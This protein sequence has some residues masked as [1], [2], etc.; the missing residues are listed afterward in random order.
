V[1]LCVC[2]C[3]YEI[4][5]LNLGTLTPVAGMHAI[6]S[7]FEQW[8]RIHDD[9]MACLSSSCSY[10]TLTVRTLFHCLYLTNAIIIGGLLLWIALSSL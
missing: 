1:C 5:A 2:V 9:F 3:V 4:V 6:V 8:W 7:L 10:K